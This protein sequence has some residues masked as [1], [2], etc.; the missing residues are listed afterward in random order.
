MNE[1][2]GIYR[3]LYET[4]MSLYHKCSVKKEEVEDNL[5]YSMWKY[6]KI[7]YNHIYILLV[8]LQHASGYCNN[9]RWCSLLFRKIYCRYIVM[10]YDI[11]NILT[12]T[13]PTI[14]NSIYPSRYI[15]IYFLFF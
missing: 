12:N 10:S 15:F 8:I 3:I 2:L 11:F 9:H 14:L 7:D 13:Y 5:Y 1:K 4:F 6:L